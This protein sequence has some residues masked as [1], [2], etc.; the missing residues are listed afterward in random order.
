MSDLAQRIA[1]LSP[2][3]LALLERHLNPQPGQSGDPA[4]P[5][6][7]G[8]G[9]SAER[10]GQPS[11]ARFSD[12]ELGEIEAVLKQHPAVHQVALMVRESGLGERWLLAYLVPDRKLARPVWQLL[13]LQSEGHLAGRLRYELPNGMVIIHLNRSETEYVYRE[14]FEEQ[15]YLKH[16]IS[17]PKGACIFDVGAHIG[18]FTL[19]VSQACQDAEI[20]AFEPIPPIFSALRLNTSVYG[21][22]ARL[23]ALGIADE[24]GTAA[25]SYYPHA[26]VLSGRY[27]DAATERHTVK[28]S[29]QTQQQLGAGDTALPDDVLDELLQARLTTELFT[30]PVKTLSQVIREN[31]VERIDLLKIDVE[32]SEL[33]VLDGLEEE[34][35]PKIRQLV[36]EV[37]DIEGRLRLI[38]A[39]LEARGYKL[40]VE[41]DAV[42]RETGIYN[43][44]A[45]R[46]PDDDSTSGDVADV[47]E[48]AARRA[49]GSW[50]SPE[51]LVNEVQQF[52]AQRLPE[53]M[54]P[55]SLVLLDALPLTTD[56]QVDRRALLSLDR[57]K[58]R[59]KGEFVAPVTPHEEKLASIWAEILGVEHVG[60]H[61]NFFELSGDWHQTARLI[62][63]V[64]QT[65]DL[66]LPVRTI[67]AEPTVAGFASIVTR[68][69]SASKG[70]HPP[71]SG[72]EGIREEELPSHPDRLSDEDVASYLNHLISEEGE[73]TAD[74]V[75]AIVA[76]NES[77]PVR[78]VADSDMTAGRRGE[79]ELLAEIGKLADEDVDALLFSMFSEEEILRAHAGL[80]ADPAPPRERFEWNDPGSSAA[81][82]GR[83]PF[84]A[85]TRRSPD[86]LYDSS[87]MPPDA[88]QPFAQV[89]LDYMKALQMAS[90]TAQ[91]QAAEAHSVYFRSLQEAWERGEEQGPFEEAYWSY[92][93]ALREAEGQRREL[94]RE[95][96]V[97]YLRALQEVWMQLDVDTLRPGSLM[98]VSHAMTL[99]ANFAAT[100]LDSLGM[101]GGRALS[102]M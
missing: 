50:S 85:E 75:A 80:D 32:K 70:S 86:N 25:F 12:D 54:R 92:E 78:G 77:A 13:R 45:I 19:F 6:P 2:E 64:R 58:P 17:L 96:Y 33:D 42:L 97:S 20:Y 55:E 15:S 99:A 56:G 79:I 100:T 84:G 1:A 40:T 83:A 27:A 5:D 18:L 72:S 94:L 46:P 102:F 65:F 36:V 67:F 39:R 69:Q 22:N 38:T 81:S 60:V 91:T 73:T 44:Y 68:A 47:G 11:V 23:F 41:Q 26:S 62:S 76:R 31:N 8:N 37:H 53:R 95:A 88:H 66:D 7:N 10:A 43:L 61:D 35:W 52:I 34:D 29:L 28:A 14:I 49:S 101:I 9:A 57:A 90:L 93:E 4:R 71:I 87:A 98:A 48:P 89:Y 74:S 63:R 82:Q 24:A 51:R 3:K 16:G 59:S 21:V 30:A